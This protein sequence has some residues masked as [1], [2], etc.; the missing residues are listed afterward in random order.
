MTYSEVHFSRCLFVGCV[1]STSV[2]EYGPALRV[3]TFQKVRRKNAL[4][5]TQGIYGNLDFG[6]VCCE[7]TTHVERFELCHSPSISSNKDSSSV[8][9]RY[10]ANYCCRFGAE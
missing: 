9:L 10:G 5:G 6:D 1:W 8:T 7:P 4:T 2:L 3:S